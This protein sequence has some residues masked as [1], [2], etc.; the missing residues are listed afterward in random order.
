MTKAEA[1]KLYTVAEAGAGTEG[2]RKRWRLACHAL[3]PLTTDAKALAL[4]A[5]ANETHK[6]ADWR[7]AARALAVALDATQARPVT[8]KPELREMSLCEFLAA[9]G[10]LSDRGGDLQAMGGAEWH[11]AKA[12]RRRLIRPDGLCTDYACDLAL[13][14]GYFDHVAPSAWDGPDNMHPVTPAMLMAA[15]ERELGGR[16]VYPNATATPADPFAGD[17]EYEA[18][19]D[20]AGPIDAALAQWAEAA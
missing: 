19:L 18:W 2:A 7:L 20:A 11:K 4:Y 17:P 5:T 16:P 14:R 15:I 13:E 10:G 12:F 3:A 1:L 8:V 6:R 9:A